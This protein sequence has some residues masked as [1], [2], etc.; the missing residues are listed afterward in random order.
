MPISRP[1]R[2]KF[3]HF[4]LALTVFHHFGPKVFR[5]V[6]KFDQRIENSSY[7]PKPTLIDVSESFEQQS[8]KDFKRK[9]IKHFQSKC[10]GIKFAPKIS[11]DDVA[12]NLLKRPEK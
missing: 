10:L 9:T 11:K 4:S 1:I 8:K 7:Y 5:R 3:S 2:Y 6:R 12:Q